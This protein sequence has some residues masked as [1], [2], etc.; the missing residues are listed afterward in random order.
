MTIKKQLITSGR[1]RWL[2]VGCGGNFEDG[3]DYI[4]TFPEGLLSEHVRNRYHRLDI[5]NASDEALRAMGDFDLVRLQHTFEH[6]SL[7]EGQKVLSNC[8]KLLRS[9]G[10]IIITVPDLE[11]H[12]R[13]YLD[14]TYNELSDFRNWALNRIEK[15]APDSYYFSIF[16]HSMP[17]ESHKWCY[18]WNGLRH[19]INMTGLYKDICRLTIDDA[20]AEVP[21]T[22][23]RPE[24]DLC[25]IAVKR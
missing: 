12:I 11:V 21:F 18:D 8:H 7:E 5:I 14:G 22:H 20:M 16:A 6:F 19:A 15:D 9:G 24:E 13:A 2:D 25:V 1:N 3:F 17:Y 23:N 10:I 4:D